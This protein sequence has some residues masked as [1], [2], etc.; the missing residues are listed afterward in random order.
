MQNF[1][2]YKQLNTYSEQQVEHENSLFRKNHIEIV[3]CGVFI[4]AE[5]GENA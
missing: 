4:E 2:S 5:K 3:H 1:H